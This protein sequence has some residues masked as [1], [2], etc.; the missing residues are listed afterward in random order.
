MSTLQGA[1]GMTKDPNKMCYVC[2]LCDEMSR[3][4][5]NNPEPLMK[6]EDG[7]CCTDCNKSKVLPARIAKLDTSLN[8]PEALKAAIVLQKS[9]LGKGHKH[10]AD[11]TKEN[12]RLRETL[13]AI[14]TEA[15]AVQSTLDHLMDMIESCS[16]TLNGKMNK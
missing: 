15:E 3:G 14:N 16:E 11:L 13:K 2:C 4:M 6:F 12:A 10:I 7:R 5:G 9:E 1:F 8:N